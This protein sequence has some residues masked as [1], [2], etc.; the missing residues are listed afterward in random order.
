MWHTEFQS[1]CEEYIYFFLPLHRWLTESHCTAT[2]CFMATQSDPTLYK[3]VCERIKEGERLRGSERERDQGKKRDR[4]Q[5]WAADNNLF[6]A[7]TSAGRFLLQSPTVTK[8][9]D[10]SKKIWVPKS[11][12][13]LL[14]A[15]RFSRSHLFQ[16]RGGSEQSE[17][18]AGQEALLMCH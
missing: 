5:T 17:I 16:L 14:H 11:P 12:C 15:D 13:W 3:R 6:N 18:L 8:A 9:L 2:P 4:E 10:S 1:S 7:M